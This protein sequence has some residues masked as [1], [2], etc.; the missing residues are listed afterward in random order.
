MDAPHNCCS[1]VL[2]QRKQ[3]T[4]PPLTSFDWSDA[5]TNLIVTASVD[6]SCTLW[7]LNVCDRSVVSLH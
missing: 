5:E 6:M 4:C 1:F 2:L 7:D 3:D